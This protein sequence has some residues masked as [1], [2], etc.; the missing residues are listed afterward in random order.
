[1][2]DDDV[3]D[4][5]GA[6]RRAGPSGGGLLEDLDQGIA[7]PLTLGAPQIPGGGGVT[8]ALTSGGPVGGELGLGEPAQDLIE[9]GALQGPAAGGEAPGA[10]EAW[11]ILASRLSWDRWLASRVPSS[12]ARRTQSVTNPSKR[13]YPRARA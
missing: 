6:T 10:V 1:M 5:L 7:T 13:R 9:L 12:S 8:V 4:D 2:V 11:T 3:G